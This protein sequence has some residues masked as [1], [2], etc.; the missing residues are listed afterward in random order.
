LPPATH[1]VADEQLVRLAKV[2]YSQNRFTGM[3]LFSQ[4]DLACDSWQEPTADGRRKQ[5]CAKPSKEVADCTLCHLVSLIEKEYIRMTIP[6]GVAML[7]VIQRSAGR[8]MRQQGICRV[9]T[10]SA[11]CDG[12]WLDWCK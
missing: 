4:G 5:A 11:H 12:K 2:L 1:G 8:F 6:L 9:G 10:Y 3:W 7:L